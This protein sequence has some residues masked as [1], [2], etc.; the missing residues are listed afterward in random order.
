[1]VGTDGG[2]LAVPV[3]MRRGRL[4]PFQTVEHHLQAAGFEQAQLTF[5]LVEGRQLRPRAPCLITPQLSRYRSLWCSLPLCLV[6]S[7]QSPANPSCRSLRYT[8]ADISCNVPRIGTH[9]DCDQ[10]TATPP[11]P[12][13]LTHP[14]VEDRFLRRT[15]PSSP[16]ECLAKG[17][18]SASR[19]ITGWP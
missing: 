10:G 18:V 17:R 2:G 11:K 5:L 14:E 7:R 15:E 4:G 9:H 3:P 13:T 6:A 19:D 1:M 16:D 8:A 12:G